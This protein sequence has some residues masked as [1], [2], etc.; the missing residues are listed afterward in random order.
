MNVHN[1]SLFPSIVTET[2]CNLYRCIR[3]DLINWIYNY[4]SKTEGVVHSN[5]GGWQSPPNFHE[6]ESFL[7][8][9]EYILSHTFQS[10]SYYKCNFNL[11][12]M[13]I[14][15]N[16]KGDYNIAHNHPNSILSGVF[17]VKSPDNCGKLVFDSP[18]NFTEG[19]LL[20]SIDE[21][22]RQERN[23]SFTFNFTPNEGTLILFPSHLQHFVESNESN[24]DRISIAFNLYVC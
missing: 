23:Y 9:K 10:L 2:E 16:K 24:E 5:R 6:L 22:V 12:N 11:S 4:Q 19:S 7:E 8:F 13:W 21:N 15:I 3:E 18:N 1:Y 20:N 14:N 17:W